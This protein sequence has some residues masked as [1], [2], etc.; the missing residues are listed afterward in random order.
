MAPPSGPDRRR[1][2]ARTTWTGGTGRSLLPIGHGPSG[3][4]VFRRRGGERVAGRLARRCPPR[5]PA[6]FLLGTPILPRRPGS[7]PA[8]PRSPTGC[9]LDSDHRRSG[10]RI[11]G[12]RGAGAGGSRSSRRR[13]TARPRP[14]L[15]VPI[16]AADDEMDPRVACAPISTTAG[17]GQLG[18]PRAASNSALASTRGLLEARRCARRSRFGRD[19][20]SVP[21]SFVA[22]DPLDRSPQGS[23]F[24]VLAR[25]NA[26][27]SQARCAACYRDETAARA[28]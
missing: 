2:P 15:R 24:T 12:R 5:A 16:A 17:L 21:G 14:R 8:S 23:I 26:S 7:V 22:F 9:H 6:I 27:G 3:A 10:I 11:R 13:S 1:G 19:A 28:R 4:P 25:P 20:I 18:R